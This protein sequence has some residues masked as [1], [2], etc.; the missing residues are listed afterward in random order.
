MAT[1]WRT[2][3]AVAG[4]PYLVRV[5][6]A[7]GL[8]VLAEFATWIAVL[9]Y[10]FEQG[11]T[12]TAAVLAVVQLV[13]GILV[14]PLAASVTER[15]SPIIVLT[16]GYMLQS[17]T[18]AGTAVVLTTGAP[19]TAV[20]IGAVLTS[21]AVT[22]T[23]PAAIAALPALSA[24]ET[25]LTAANVVAGWLE[26][27]AT[28]G[29]GLLVGVALVDG[30]PALVFTV[31]A[32]GVG[33]SALLVLGIKVPMVRTT[34]ESAG[35]GCW[36]SLRGGLET[37]AARPQARVLVGLITAMQVLIG[38]LDVLLV[39]LAVTVLRQGSEWTGYLNA[40]FGLGGLLAALMTVRL[41]GRSLGKA[42]VL[43]ATI[44]WFGIVATA[45]SAQAVLTV[46]LLMIMGLGISVLRTATR[47]LLQR[48]VPAAQVGT[49]FGVVEGLSMAGL[50]VGAGLVPLL[51][52]MGG[53]IAAVLGIAM[54]LPL[55]AILG[56]R[57]LLRLDT[58]ACVPVTEISALRSD[59]ALREVS[60]VVIE[61]LA[62]S[63]M[64]RELA[65]GV[66]IVRTGEPIEAV[67]LLL[68]GSVDVS[69]KSTHRVRAGSTAASMAGLADAAILDRTTH[70]ATVTTS[71]PVV[72]LE[73]EATAYRAALQGPPVR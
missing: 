47:A 31:S 25:T 54:V 36:A 61:Q 43:S 45:F 68:R 64:R 34:A 65:D 71:G 41:P 20:Y 70:L 32:I 7:G 3:A 26:D 1:S 57:A 67:R 62:A 55:S 35:R 63:A 22:M 50:A 4:N 2:V 11:G 29:A 49:V 44:A 19:S 53:P 38:A 6:A 56:G 21:T 37:I 24:G 33:G 9:I 69:G 40:A 42:V 17:V 12:T 73:I 28:V 10:A 48:T 27:A 72:L 59:P 8:F 23:R 52:A 14:G 66:V 60:T 46:V 39:I 15:R 30:S 5:L 13:P 16:V 51:A 18:M 58:A